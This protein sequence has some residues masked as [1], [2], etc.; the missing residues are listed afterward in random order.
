MPMI[1]IVLTGPVAAET[2][3]RL[4][5]ESVARVAKATGKPAAV[6]MA[7]VVE[8]DL[9]MGD[10]DVAAGAQPRPAAYVEVRAIGG[11]NRTVNAEITRQLGALLQEAAGVPIERTY[12]SFTEVAATHWGWKGATLG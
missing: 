2:R 6:T 11:L 10:S 5:G 12:V 9:A 7:S 1:Q 8:G 4:A 3:R